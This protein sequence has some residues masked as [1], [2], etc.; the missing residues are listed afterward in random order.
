MKK[1]VCIHLLNDYSGSPFM[2]S[3]VIDILLNNNYETELFTSDTNGFLSNINIKRN[4]IFYKRAN[5]KIAVLLNYLISQIILFLTLLKYKNEDVVFYISTIMPFGAALAGKILGKKV[6]YHIHETSVKPKILK[7]FLF[8]IIQLTS[9]KNIFVSNFLAKKENIEQIKSFTI[10]N[11]L[12]KDFT[13]KSYQH[14][15]LCDGDFNILMVCSLKEYK[16]ILELLEI[17]EQCLENKKINFTLVLNATQDE[18][19][20]YLKDYTLASNILIFSAQKNIH[21]FYEKST[22][23]MNLS[24]VD[25]WIETFGM[26]ILEALSYGI[27][28]IVPPV[29]GPIELVD[30]GDNGYCISSYKIE[31]IVAIINGLEKDRTQLHILS[32][33]ARQK[34]FLFSQENFSEAILKV[35]NE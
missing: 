20:I 27:P 22:L 2:L 18:I 15:Y 10:Y 26:T 3:Q 31:E 11:A 9:D 13:E 32:D 30:N 28:C 16:G 24:R 12:P 8:K 14:Q 1:I 35:F 5:N 17:A 33:K 7:K 6:I 29:G 25:A 34:S 23:L 21:P 4:N 19:N